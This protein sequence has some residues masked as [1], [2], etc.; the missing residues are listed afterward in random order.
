MH[1]RSDQIDHLFELRDSLREIGRLDT[2]RKRVNASLLVFVES[3]AHHIWRANRPEA[4][5]HLIGN[6]G[7]C[8]LAFAGNPEA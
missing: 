6:A 8:L 2:Q 4:R 5:H 7:D 3:F 1:Q